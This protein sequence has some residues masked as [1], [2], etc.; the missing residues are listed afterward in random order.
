[1]ALHHLDPSQKDIGFGAIRANPT[2]WDKIV[3]ELRKCVLVCH[4]CHGEIHAG[5]VSVP[6]SVP[7]FNEDFADYRKLENKEHL[8]PCPICKEPK[9]KELVTCSKEC[10]G[11]K[12]YKVNWDTINLIDELKKKSIIALAEELGCSDGAI[13]KRLR[14]LGLK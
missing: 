5:M 9:R 4:N 8:E 14:R 2:N 12:R 13:H 3:A 1:M 11:K 7:K 6:R 10:A